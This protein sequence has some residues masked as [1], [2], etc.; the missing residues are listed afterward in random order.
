MSV[1]Y[2]V[3]KYK[4][5]VRSLKFTDLIAERTSQSHCGS[6]AEETRTH[7]RHCKLRYKRIEF[8][9]KDNKC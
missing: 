8:K 4:E 9:V 1:K 2:T 7:S 6:A 3:V 5:L